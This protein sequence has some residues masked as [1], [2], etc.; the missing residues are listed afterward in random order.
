MLRLAASVRHDKMKRASFISIFIVILSG[1]QAQEYNPAITEIIKDL[2][3]IHNVKSLYYK[4]S[5]IQWYTYS[6]TDLL[7]WCKSIQEFNETILSEDSIEINNQ[8]RLSK[9]IKWNKKNISK[10]ILKRKNANH[11]FSVPIFLNNS[12]NIF[13]IYHSEYYN[14]EA[15]TGTI[16]IYEKQDNQWKLLCSMLLYIS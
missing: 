15:A 1:I 14:P 13:L 5:K 12:K 16:E 3:E 10:E 9:S 7:I 8:I 6:K 2:C 11:S 4:S